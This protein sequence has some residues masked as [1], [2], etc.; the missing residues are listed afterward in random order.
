MADDDRIKAASSELDEI[1]VAT[2]SATEDIL[3]SAKHIGE[4]LDEILARHSTD[5]KLYALTEEAGQELVNIMEACSF[6]DI[7][8]QRVNKIGKTIRYIQDRIVAMIGI[9]DTEAFID[10]PV[11]EEQPQN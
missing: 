11:K 4:L 7:T 5:E 2:Q 1:V 6:Q 9:W 10:L 8:G 3:H